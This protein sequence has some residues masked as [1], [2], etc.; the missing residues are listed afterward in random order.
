MASNR[1]HNQIKDAIQ[2][3]EREEDVAQLIGIL[4]AAKREAPQPTADPESF[5]ATILCILT[6]PVKTAKYREHASLFRRQFQGVA[7]SGAV[8]DAFRRS[9]TATLL[10]APTAEDAV[11]QG[12]ENLFVVEAGM[13]A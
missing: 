9:I 3:G 7:E 4:A 13:G 10:S 5:A 6:T 1:F 11:K 12:F 8:R 2:P